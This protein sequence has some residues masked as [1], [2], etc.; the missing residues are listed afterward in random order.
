MGTEGRRIY[1]GGLPYKADER[2]LRD[3]CNKYGRIEDAFIVLDKYS[4]HRRSKGYGFVTFEDKADARD[5]IDALDG[6]DYDGRRLTVQEARPNNNSRGGG[7]GGRR[8]YGGGR[9]D[10]GSYR[11]GSRGGDREDYGGRDRGYGGGGGGGG[12]G[13]RSRRDSYG[14]RDRY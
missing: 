4:D 13:G 12:G 2:D 8:D 7:G 3:L 1:V 9:R 14:D 5:C 10:G 6:T 11:G